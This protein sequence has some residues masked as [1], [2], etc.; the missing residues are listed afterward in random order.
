VGAFIVGDGSAKSQI[1]PVLNIKMAAP[2]SGPAG[3]LACGQKTQVQWKRAA[4]NQPGETAMPL[5]EWAE[6]SGWE[7]VHQI[8]M[9]E[10]LYWVQPRLPGG[11]RAYIGTTPAFAIDAPAAERPDVGVRD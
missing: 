3:A 4:K 1:S 9:V 8:W 7:G 6:L 2:F 10:L 5:H 11:Y